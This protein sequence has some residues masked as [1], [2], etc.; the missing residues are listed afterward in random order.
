[1]R[2]AWRLERVST[3]RLG[4]DILVTGDVARRPAKRR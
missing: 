3:R 2:D 4:D 1:M